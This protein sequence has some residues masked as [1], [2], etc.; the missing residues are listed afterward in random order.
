[1]IRSRFEQT[2]VLVCANS[3]II[4]LFVTACPIIPYFPKML[5]E[6]HAAGA[7]AELEK[8]SFEFAL[9]PV[10]LYQTWPLLREHNP[11]AVSATL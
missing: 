4:H 10:N 5:I 2:I 6:N 11:R 1:M 3:E 9:M 8:I 7:L